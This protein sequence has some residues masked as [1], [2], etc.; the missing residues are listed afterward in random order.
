MKAS[1]GLTRGRGM[2]ELQ[3]TIWT[4]AMPTLVLVNERMQNLT[5]LAELAVENHAEA[6]SSRRARDLED[7]EKIVRYI[8][9]LEPFRQDLELLSV[10][11]GVRASSSVNADDAKSVEEYILKDMEAKDIDKY[12]FRRKEKAVTMAERTSVVID[13]ERVMVDPALILQRLAA[14]ASTSGS[15]LNEVLSFELCSFPP[16]LFSSFEVMRTAEKAALTNALMK[17]EELDGPETLPT[18]QRVLDGG[19]LV[20][21]IPF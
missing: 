2:T 13:S 3:R 12:V 8:E 18:S 9:P 16:S 4:S 7:I 5:G 15:D 17:I 6:I 19:W 1:G 21:K 11:T 20:H 10:V 14:V